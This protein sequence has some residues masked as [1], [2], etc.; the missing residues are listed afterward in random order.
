MRVIRNNV[1]VLNPQS[2]R[3]LI[4]IAAAIHLSTDVM[5]AQTVTTRRLTLGVSFV[6]PARNREIGETDD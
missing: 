5:P 2:Y 4:H 1:V 3:Q 6:L